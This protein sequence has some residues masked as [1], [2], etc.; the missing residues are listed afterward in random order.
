MMISV[1]RRFVKKLVFEDDILDCFPEEW[2]MCEI[3]D[4]T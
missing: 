4:L 2:G 3:I 1:P